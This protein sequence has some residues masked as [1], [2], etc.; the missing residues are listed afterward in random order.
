MVE[1]S[2]EMTKSIDENK[3]PSNL[4]KEYYEIIRELIL[5]FYF[6]SLNITSIFST[7][8]LDFCKSSVS[9]ALFTSVFVPY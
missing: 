7:I 4:T 2:L 5:L 9:R 1:L 6:I 8:A 3:F